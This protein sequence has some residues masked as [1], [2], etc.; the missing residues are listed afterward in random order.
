[1]TLTAK[2]AP[3]LFTGHTVTLGGDIGVNFYLDDEVLDTYAGTKT[4]PRP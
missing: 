2:F 3:K 1:M 4:V